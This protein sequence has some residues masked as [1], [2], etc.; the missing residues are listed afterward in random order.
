[1][2]AATKAAT[3]AATNHG[4]KPEHVVHTSASPTDVVA[5]DT[6][7]LAPSQIGDV[8][9]VDRMDGAARQ[10]LDPTIKLQ[11]LCAEFRAAH[12]CDPRA[13]GGSGTVF[14]ARPATILQLMID[15][16]IGPLSGGDARP[17]KAMIFGSRDACSG[18]EAD[19]VARWCDVPIVVRSSAV[20]NALYCVPLEQLPESK[21]VD[22]VR[23]GQ[24]RHAIHAGG[25]AELQRLREENE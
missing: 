17:I 1:V 14:V 3:K 11:L 6:H 10:A 19:V 18:G 22:R 25:P 24:I 13:G 5:P 4:Q 20:G 12:G 16:K 9:D 7:A 8:V 23:A 15:L 21:G 2:T